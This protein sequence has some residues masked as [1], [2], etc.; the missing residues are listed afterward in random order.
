MNP[1]LSNWAANKK[2]GHVAA[3][4]SYMAMASIRLCLVRARFTHVSISATSQGPRS[5]ALQESTPHR[6]ERKRMLQCLQRFNVQLAKQV[7]F[8]M[9]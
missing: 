4:Y 9:F 8:E 3:E 5:H 7:D 6:I 1:A 2:L